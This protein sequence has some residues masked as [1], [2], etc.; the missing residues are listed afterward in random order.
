MTPLAGTLAL[1]FSTH[2]PPKPLMPRNSWGPHHLLIWASG[3]ERWNQGH[4]PPTPTPVQ[5][6]ALP[7]WVSS[8][9]SIPLSNTLALHPSFNLHSRGQEANSSNAAIYCIAPGSESVGMDGA[10]DDSEPPLD[11]M[12][13]LSLPGPYT[14]LYHGT[15][16]GVPGRGPN[17]LPCPCPSTRHTVAATGSHP[18]LHP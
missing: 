10:Q 6:P 2:I 7:F 13:H 4:H 1:F 12:V 15:P 3:G 9:Q 11:V 5:F 17:P 18:N 16:F 14:D 8:H